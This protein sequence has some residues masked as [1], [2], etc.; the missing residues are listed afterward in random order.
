MHPILGQQLSI[1]Q[2]ASINSSLT[3][4]KASKK[5]EEG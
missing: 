2:F 3:K 1:N 5:Q 4:K